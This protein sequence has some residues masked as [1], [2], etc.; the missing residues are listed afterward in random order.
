MRA[1][2]TV[3]DMGSLIGKITG[4]GLVLGKGPVE[5]QHTRLVV[6][7]TIKHRLIL[8]YYSHP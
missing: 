2:Y 8:R 4:H 1:K 3:A 5:D 6:V 7:M